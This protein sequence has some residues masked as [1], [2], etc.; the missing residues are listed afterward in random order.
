MFLLYVLY[1]QFHVAFLFLNALHDRWS[2]YQNGTVIED[3]IAVADAHPLGARPFG[4]EQ[5]EHKFRSLAQGL[6][7]PEEID[8]FLD[9]AAQLA[10]LP[11][12]ELGRLNIQ[13]APGVVEASAG[14]KGLF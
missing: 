2:F 11:A 3:S 9:A 5:Y 8:R 6:V 12:G 1:N 10:H 4:R 13:A 7:E 14:P